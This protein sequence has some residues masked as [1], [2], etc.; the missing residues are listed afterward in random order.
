MIALLS[1]LLVFADDAEVAQI[2]KDRGATA[3]LTKGII[4]RLEVGDCSKWTDEDFRRVGSLSGLKDLSVGAG[5][6]DAT[7]ALLCGLPELEVLQT[8]QGQVSDEGV[9]AL[10]GLKKLKVLK[11]FH[12]GKTFSG[13]GLASLTALERLTVAGSLSFA[14]E[15][16]AAVGKLVHLKE[17]RTWHAGHTL[18]GVKSL[19]DLKELKSL[20]LGQRLAYKPPTSLS[21]DSL[22]VLAEMTSLES[23]R[24]EEARLKGESLVQLKK[25]SSL[26]TL[27][28][29]GIDIPE[30]DVD[31]LKKELPAV[32]VQWTKPNETYQKRIQALFGR[33]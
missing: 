14:D 18:E 16:M 6:T 31:R 24:L 4:T 20:T 5:L 25:L 32:A 11:L 33:E 3:V 2:L 21:D 23:L 15:G 1:L 7:L 13:T 10:V 27:V 26:K 30:P 12:P 8:N 22:A 17:F 9:K 28:L 29:E 19:R